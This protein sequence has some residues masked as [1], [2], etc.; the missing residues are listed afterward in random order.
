MDDLI[1]M[2]IEKEFMQEML[3]AGHKRHK[4]IITDIK[5]VPKGAIFGK[6]AVFKIFNRQTKT[7]TTINGGSFKKNS[8]AESDAENS[9]SV[10][11]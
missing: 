3:N 5:D 1:K 6:N 7:E 9:D 11:E 2:K 4:K 8:V 10:D